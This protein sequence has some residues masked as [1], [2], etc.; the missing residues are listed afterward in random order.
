MAGTHN[1]INALQR[2]PMFARLAGGQAPTVNFDNSN[3]YYNGY[4][5][6]D[7]IYPQWSTFDSCTKLGEEISLC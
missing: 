5:L 3:R 1:D 6:A 7:G 4:Y 2:S